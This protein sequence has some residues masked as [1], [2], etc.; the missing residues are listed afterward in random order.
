MTAVR[1][2]A[3]FGGIVF[4]GDRVKEFTEKPQIGEGWI[5]GGF[6]VFEPEVFRYVQGDST[7][8]ESDTLESLAR[9]GQLMAFRHE[10]YWQCMDTVRDLRL[11]ESAW[12]NSPPWR[13]W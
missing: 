10:R 11:L 12:E 7:V 1:P 9:D 6:M 2:P 5:N 13:V 3:R 4:E 8:L